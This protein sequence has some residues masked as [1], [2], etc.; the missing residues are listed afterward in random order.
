MR[1]MR[2]TGK[3]LLSLNKLIFRKSF[4]HLITTAYFRNMFF[5]S[6]L[7]LIVMIKKEE[8]NPF[9]SIN[10]LISNK[11][12]NKLNW[13]DVNQSLEFMSFKM[14]FEGKAEAKSWLMYSVQHLV[15]LNSD[16]SI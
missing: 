3:P 7:Y 1:F 2:Y 11:F 15:Y 6:L 13:M 16:S 9:I 12:H 4:F 5:K 10:R 8:R 14:K